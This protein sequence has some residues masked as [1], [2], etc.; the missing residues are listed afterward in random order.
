[1]KDGTSLEFSRIYKEHHRS[2]LGYV[3]KLLGREEADDVVQEIFI[4]V[5]RALPTLTDPDKRAAWIHTIALNTVRDTIRRRSA[6]A[7]RRKDLASGE[8]RD[9][10]L[11][12][13]PDRVSRTPEERVIRGEMIACYLEYIARL[14]PTYREAYVLAELEDLS[15]DEIARRL[16]VSVAT[17]KI[18]LHRARA[19]LHESLRCDCRAYT[20][21]RGELMGTRKCGAGGDGSEP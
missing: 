4:K 17:V 8:D 19:K 21:A 6:Q 10:P 7:S 13:L 3:V 15:N 11:A 9:D 14:P 18:R 12:G 16:S 2:V 20:N 5:R 1:V